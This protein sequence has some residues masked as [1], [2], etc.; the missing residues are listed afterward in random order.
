MN[1]TASDH[2]APKHRSPSY[3]AY[4]L[5][6]SLTRTKQLSDLAGTHP[7]NIA[8]V[9][10]HW[11]YSAKSSKGLL[12]VAALKKFALAEDA[13]K[14]DARTIF[15]TVLGRELAYY[16]SERS[17]EE[18]RTRARTAAMTPSIH[19]ELWSRYDGRLP[20]DSVMKDYLVLTR[21]FNE[22][23]AVELLSEFRKTL[24]F[25]GIGTSDGPGIVAPDQG[26]TSE[27]QEPRMP[28]TAS[29]QAPTTTPPSPAWP[30]APADPAAPERQARKEPAAP[31]PVNVNLSGGGWAVLQVS[32]RLTDTQWKQ[33]IAALEAQKPGL[34][35]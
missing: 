16:D 13:G 31:L 1:E 29:P 15:L 18:W 33:M 27:E 32:E 21:G 24:A 8:T 2:K 35:S 6:A 19:R 7:A 9:V 23:A 22:S 25:A 34:L 4:D 3:P 11:G 5:E 17:N 14:G 12:M 28:V 30:P 26:N 20:T 10:S